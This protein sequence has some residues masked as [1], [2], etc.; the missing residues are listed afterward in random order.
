MDRGYFAVFLSGFPEPDIFLEE[1]WRGD[2]VANDIHTEQQ[3]VGVLQILVKRGNLARCSGEE[4]WKALFQVFFDGAVY[5]SGV[6]L[7]IF[8]AAQG[9]EFLRRGDTDVPDA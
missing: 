6:A 4:Y 9:G 1:L 7:D 2:A 8:G 3:R 5:P